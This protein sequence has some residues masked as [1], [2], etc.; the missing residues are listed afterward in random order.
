MK[1]SVHT[2]KIFQAI[3]ESQEQKNNF[4]EQYVGL[5]VVELGIIVILLSV[6]DAERANHE[7]HA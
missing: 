1:E 4:Q 6:M 7:A 2:I 3:N 5:H